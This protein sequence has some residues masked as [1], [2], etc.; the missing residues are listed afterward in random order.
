MRY[1]SHWAGL[2]TDGLRRSIAALGLAVLSSQPILAADVAIPSAQPSPPNATILATAVAPDGTMPA[3][4]APITP[5]T[6]AAPQF[7]RPEAMEPRSDVDLR[8]Q[9]NA[10]Q[11]AQR[12]N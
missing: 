3:C 7:D 5:P 9:Q 11:N 2:F 10:N 6:C 8:N 1:T 12:R 4:A